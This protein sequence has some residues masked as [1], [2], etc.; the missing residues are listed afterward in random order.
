MSSYIKTTCCQNITQKCCSGN[1]YSPKEDTETLISKLNS[2]ITQLEQQEKDF[3]LLNEEF[4]QLE[5]DYTLL[6]EEKLRLEYEIKQREET[7]NKR[8]SDLKSANENLKNGLNDK[9]CVNQ[10]LLEEKNCLEKH[11]KAKK[12]EIDEVNKKIDEA[13]NK[14]NGTQNNKDNLQNQIDELNNI[15]LNQ[16]NKIEELVNDNKKLAKICKEQDHALY[17][18]EQE[19]QNLNLKLRNDNANINNLSSK[20]R[21]HSNNLTNLQKELD[22]SN[23]LNLNLNNNLKNLESELTNLKIDNDNLN[24]EFV[25]ELHSRED[26]DKKNDELKCI[27]ADRQNKLK[28]LNNDYERMKIAHHKLSEERGMYQNENEKLKEHIII[29]T[30]QNQ[31]LI[32]EIDNVIKDDENMKDIL[33]RCDRMSYIIKETENLI[34]K[35]PNEVICVNDFDN[36]NKSIGAENNI[37]M[38]KSTITREGTFSP[39]FTYSIERK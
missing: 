30:R 7:N 29:L 5:N 21:I 27:L 26:E 19:K 8:I 23:T 35:V 39:K 3:N 15:K 22:N 24:N 31:D 32:D 9:N 2:R 11:L 13:N 37:C 10:K 25:L 34:S 6:N 17:L 20:I 12:D 33:N 4:K 28:C 1:L 38:T 16:K 36:Y 14:I 18:S